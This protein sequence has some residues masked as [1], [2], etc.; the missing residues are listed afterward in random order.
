[1]YGRRA[2]ERLV[3]RQVDG[4]IKRLAASK[5]HLVACEGQRVPRLGRDRIAEPGAGW[6][7]RPTGAAET[8]DAVLG[9]TL[10]LGAEI[11]NPDVVVRIHGHAP[12]AEHAAAEGAGNLSLSPDR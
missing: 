9:G 2:H 4:R 5:E 7:S 10:L 1:V 3:R 6:T 11:R 12:G 8:G